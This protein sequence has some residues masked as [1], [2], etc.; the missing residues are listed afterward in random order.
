MRYPMSLALLGL[1]ASVSVLPASAAVRK[2]P[3]QY[4]TIQS[5]IN[6]AHSGDT[7]QVSPKSGSDPAYHENVV[8]ATSLTLQGLR[9]ATIDGTGTSFLDDP[10][11]TGTPFP[12][13][14]DAVVV[15]AANVTITGLT[16]KNFLYQVDPNDLS[17][18]P[19][20]YVAGIRVDPV[21]NCH[22]L[23]NTILS[24]YNGIFLNGSV[25]PQVSGNTIQGCA[26]GAY[27]VD[28]TQLTFTSNTVTNNIDVTDAYGILNQGAGVSISTGGALVQSNEIAHNG[29]G[30]SI[31]NGDFITGTNHVTSN[32]VH[33][34]R[35]EGIFVGFGDT[36]VVC[37]NNVFSNGIGI[38]LNG[39]FDATVTKNLVYNN[40]GEAGNGGLGPNPGDGIL[41]D[42]G[43]SSPQFIIPDNNTISQNILT[44][45]HGDGIHIFAMNFF[46]TII[47]DMGNTVTQNVAVG[48][49]LFD[50]EDDTYD[51]TQVYNSWTLDVFG[52]TSPAGLLH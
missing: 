30:L 1:L 29:G 9:G 13:Q 44:G 41:I 21:S 52:T 3:S 12:Y 32:N 14:H 50:A 31:S 42:G 43:F 46:G 38:H 18:I 5:A 37:Q 10:F 27:C 33:D 22:I 25:S 28:P 19:N 45:N 48:D 40:I 34:N 49:V 4:P 8:I 26:V 35:Y 20:G 24:V 7:V 23:N 39:V 17:P 36:T 51:G 15:Q 11:N 16:I 47:G 2:V 6:A